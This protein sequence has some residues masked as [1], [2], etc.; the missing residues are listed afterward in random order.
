MQLIAA[1]IA[2]GALLIA[3]PGASAQAAPDYHIEASFLL[4]I[5]KFVDW[6][7]NSFLGPDAPFTICVVG[8]DPFGDALDSI[9]SVG[10]RSVEVDRFPTMRSLSEAQCCQIAFIS[11]SEKTRFRKIIGLFKGKGSLLVSDS[12][13]FAA[14]GGTVEFR[15]QEGQLRI[16]INPEAAD[17]AHLTVSSK[18]LAISVIVHEEQPKGNGG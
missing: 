5:A 14:S 11:S 7:N 17:R 8:Q 12:D 1:I 16:A 9:Q 10:N 2:I 6:P 4:N 15:T 13:G 3:A 18:L